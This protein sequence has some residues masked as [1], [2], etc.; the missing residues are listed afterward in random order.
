MDHDW[1]KKGWNTEDFSRNSFTPKAFEA[2]VRTA[3]Q[4]A[5]D[6]VWIYT[7][8][9]RWWTAEGKPAKLPKPY[10]DALRRAAKQP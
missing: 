2:S 4:T 1:R 10:D 8:T 3:L 6:Y 9:P 5:D 7:E